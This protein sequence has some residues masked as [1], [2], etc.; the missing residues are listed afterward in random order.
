MNVE[1]FEE[2]LNDKAD[3]AELADALV[4]CEWDSSMTQEQVEKEIETVLYEDDAWAMIYYDE[5][6]DF[7]KN[8][9][10]TLSLSLSILSQRGSFNGANVCTLA[11]DMLAEMLNTQYGSFISD[12]VDE[13]VFDEDSDADYDV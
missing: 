2:L 5:A 10:P 8:V 7:L 6:W 11:N 3:Y 12:C 4:D 1:L 9:D 13:G